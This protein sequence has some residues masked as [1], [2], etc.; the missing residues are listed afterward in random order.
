MTDASD[1]L[2]ALGYGKL[3]QLSPEAAVRAHEAAGIMSARLPDNLTPD[4]EPAAIYRPEA[5]NEDD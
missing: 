4:I 1:K 5:A 2:T 3:V